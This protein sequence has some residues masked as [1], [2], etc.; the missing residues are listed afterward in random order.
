M[1]RFNSTFWWAALG[2]AVLTAAACVTDPCDDCT[3]NSLSVILFGEISDSAGPLLEAV[4]LEGVIRFP[5]CGG[6][7]NG[8]TQTITVDAGSYE[9]QVFT[10]GDGPQCVDL[11]AVRDA[12][13]DTVVIRELALQGS[14]SPPRVQVDIGF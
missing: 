9:L 3:S 13:S 2:V 14:R 8:T 6:P 5:V 11:I 1:K 10:F 4:T 12:T 7:P